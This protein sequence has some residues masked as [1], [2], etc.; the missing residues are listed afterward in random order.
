MGLRATIIK[1]Y[2]VEYGNAQGFNYGST[3]ISNLINTYC[4]CCNL[5]GEFNDTDSF[6][7]VDK[8]EFAAM[9]K[10]IEEIPAK[11]FNKRAVDEW[12]AEKEDGFTKSYVL[13]TF[14]AWLKETPEDTTWVRFGWI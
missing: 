7:E 14:K 3:F 4:D 12:G 13:R 8:D 6:W 11:E 5:G 1:T 2:K 9:V 10:K